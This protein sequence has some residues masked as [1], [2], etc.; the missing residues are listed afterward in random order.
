MTEPYT[1]HDRPYTAMTERQSLLT[2]THSMTERLKTVTERP[3]SMTERPYTSMTERSYTSPTEKSQDMTTAAVAGSHKT[4]WRRPC[5][6]H[7]EYTAHVRSVLNTTIAQEE[8][9]MTMA[10][11]EKRYSIV[12]VYNPIHVPD[13]SLI[14]KGQQNSKCK[15]VIL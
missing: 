8:K 13:G 1:V 11:F 7:S 15:Y 2:E 14:F 12:R 10:D 3:T 4:R 6:A 5:T 9:T